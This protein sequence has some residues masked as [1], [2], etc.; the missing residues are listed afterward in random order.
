MGDNESNELLDERANADA[1]RELGNNQ[2]STETDV[3]MLGMELLAC[4]GV[5][6]GGPREID[7]PGP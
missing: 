3:S 2:N 4:S 6:G 5:S 7:A 1:A